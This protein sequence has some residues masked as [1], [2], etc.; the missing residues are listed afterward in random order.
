MCFFHQSFKNFSKQ[1]LA[2]S[3]EYPFES[4]GEKNKISFVTEASNQSL[5]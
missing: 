3:L 2:K 5:V 1:T 4:E